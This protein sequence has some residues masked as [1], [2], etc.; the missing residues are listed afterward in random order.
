MTLLEYLET[1]PNADAHSL[2]DRYNGNVWPSG[3]DLTLTDVIWSAKQDNAWTRVDLG[4]GKLARVSCYYR[5]DNTGFAVSD[6]GKSVSELMRRTGKRWEECV[7]LARLVCGLIGGT[8]A[9]DVR[10]VM[11]GRPDPASMIVTVLSSVA[12][13]MAIELKQ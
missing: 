3:C 6:C 4:D 9:G 7:T 10:L 13:I 2:L 5:P 1:F 8:N 12:R 11:H